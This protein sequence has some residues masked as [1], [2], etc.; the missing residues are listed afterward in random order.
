MS[1]IVHV[2]KGVFIRKLKTCGWE[3]LSFHFSPTFICIFLEKNWCTWIFL[4]HVCRLHFRSCFFQ[5]WFFFSSA[6]FGNSIASCIQHPSDIEYKTSYFL[7]TITNSQKLCAECISYFLFLVI[8]LFNLLNRNG[9]SLYFR[10]SFFT[11]LL[12]SFKPFP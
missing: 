6:L 12:R 5:H 8:L 11:H 2:F 3:V 9:C 10:S 1:Q 4:F 7:N